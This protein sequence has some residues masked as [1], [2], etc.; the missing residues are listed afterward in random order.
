L[1]ERCV[2]DAE[3]T[4]SNPAAPT[5]ILA[6]RGSTR[7]KA[8]PNVFTRFSPAAKRVLRL[9]E[10]ECR[11]LNHYYVGVEHLLLALCEERDAATAGFLAGRGVSC[12]DVH[13]ELRRA[14]GTGE[15]RLWPG[16]LVTPRVRKIVGMADAAAGSDNPIEPVHLLAA[17]VAEQTSMA[18]EILAS[19]E[20]N[21]RGSHQVAG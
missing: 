20:R 3:V 10:Q 11:N 12:D 6:R 18:A 2:R 1:V 21:Y 19:I 9:A 17:I 8:S 4:G 7:E 13:A 16:I 5:T 14:L 15:D